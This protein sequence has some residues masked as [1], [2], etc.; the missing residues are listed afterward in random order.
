MDSTSIPRPATQHAARTTRQ[1]ETV[2]DCVAVIPAR[3][4]SKG[5]LRKNV[6]PLAGKPLIAWTI[7]VARRC[8]Q[9][10]R[11]IVSTEDQ[12]IAEVARQY[13]AEVP[14]QRPEALASDETSGVE[15]VLHATQWLEA[16]E[17]YAPEYVMLLQ[18]TSPFRLRSDID[19]AVKLAIEE[20]HPSVASREAG[21]DV[22]NGAVYVGATHWLRDGGNWDDMHEPTVMPTW[23]S[24]DIDTEEDFELAERHIEDWYRRQSG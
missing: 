7:E 21:S 11:V 20:Q 13:G 6:R 8:P 24:L 4:S 23:R 16:H 14:F 22:P 1:H 12:E 15:V 18:P 19:D 5:L 3:G 9:L 10:D 17:G 2:L